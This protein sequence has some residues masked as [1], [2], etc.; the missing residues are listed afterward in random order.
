MRKK[1]IVSS[2]LLAALL[3][4]I[5]TGCASDGENTTL[6][7]TTAAA[8]T[9]TVDD[10]VENP[11]DVADISVDVGVDPDALEP[12]TLKYIG[13]YDLTKAGD[14]K[15]AYKY[16][17]TTYG[18]D[19]EVQIVGSAEIYDTIATGI[20]SGDS[21]DLVDRA[22]S[23]FPHFMSKNMYTALD[24]YI[25]LSA[26]QWEGLDEYIESYVWNG[27]H[28]YYP[29]S[30]SVSPYMC[31]Y[32]R[33]LFEEK[34]LDDPY[35]MYQS[36]NWTWDT[37]KDSM[38]NFVGNDTEK[39]GFYGYYA[40]SFL[41]S[42]GVAF[43]D[44]DENGKLVN[45]MNSTAVE[46]AQ[47]FLMD[48]RKQGLGSVGYKELSNVDIN[49]VLDGSA[50][51]QMMGGWVITNYF[52][53]QAKDETLD[54]FVVPF[55]RSPYADEYYQSLTTFGYLVPE[56]SQHVEQACAFINCARISTLDPD[57]KETTR[58]S[59][60]KNKK[61]TDEVYDFLQEFKDPTAFKC[62]ID[63]RFGMSTE[64]VDIIKNM[65]SDVAFNTEEQPSW[66]QLREQYFNLIQ[67]E[68]DNYNALIG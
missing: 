57:L 39:L 61:Y 7:T 43:M 46:Q 27:K 8:T 28:Y 1:K 42:N 55:P 20:A 18:C 35:E 40:T 11:V 14:I 53:E 33:G 22:D 47:N 5:T 58:E 26:P 16:F 67:D 34:G 59:E 25:D 65:L 38:V 45:N 49:P 2:M 23:T 41:N 50:A 24:D 44:L 19:I 52:K 21:A 30:Y 29:W 64:T 6:E 66:T 10:D 9:T 31:V 60:M 54:I 12:C 63:D 37:F 48:L 68:I 3:V 36:G 15:P 13:S 51:F 32:N 62:I 4:G 56:G 17:Q